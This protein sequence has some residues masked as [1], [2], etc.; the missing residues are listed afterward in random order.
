MFIK[1]FILG[2]GFCLS[3]APALAQSTPTNLT[4]GQALA[5]AQQQDLWLL[6]NQYQQAALESKRVASN[7]LPD[8]KLSL[9]V[10][11]LSS[12][13]FDF[14]QEPMTQLKLGISQMFPRGNSR[15]LNSQRYALQAGQKSIQRQDHN[16]SLAVQVLKLW[17]DAYKAKASLSLLTK[18]RSLFVDL[19]DVAEKSYSSAFGNTQQQD[20][21]RAQLELTRLDDRLSVF[22]EHYEIALAKLGEWIINDELIDFDVA[23]QPAE[24]VL[25]DLA[26]PFF[27]GNTSRNTLMELLQSHP[28]IRDIEQQLQMHNTD[29]D[30]ARQKYKPQW[31]VRA[32]Y[33]YRDDDPSGRERDDLLS[34]GV[35]FDLPLFT[36]NRQDPEIQSQLD[37]MD[38]AK[39][40]KLLALNKMAAQAYAAKQRLLRLNQ[41]QSLYENKLLAQMS[42]QANASLNAYVSDRGDFVE[43]VRARIAELNTQVEAID[44]AAERLKAIAF[45]NYL[46]THSPKQGVL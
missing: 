45:L 4:L 19:I 14:S 43:V 24:I 40:G 46:F 11:N 32:G 35:I 12:D 13:S 42:E 33:S 6:R 22:Q 17:L 16:A 30:L 10:L 3:A 25:N 15:E 38:A 29:I 18:N 9:D 36:A 1:I 21:V 2:L 23:S 20:V 39:A 5:L 37:M 44:I 31:G 8:P 27:M 28:R 41:R 7:S 34:V 26:Q